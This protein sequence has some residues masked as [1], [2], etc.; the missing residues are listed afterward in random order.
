MALIDHFWTHVLQDEFG[1]QLRAIA[2]ALTERVLPAFAGIEDEVQELRLVTNTVKHAEGKSAKTLHTLRPD[3]FQYPNTKH[4]RRS[5]H[6][7]MPPVFL[8]LIG[9]GLYISLN[10][11]EQYR[12][13]LIDFWRELS[14]KMGHA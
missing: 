9:E 3:L 6:N 2:Q 7:G 13:S 11:L 8:P 4:L 1:T 12:D 5:F 10:D 14:H